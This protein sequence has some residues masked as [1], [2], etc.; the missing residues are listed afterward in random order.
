MN[1][2]SI[3]RYRKKIVLKIQDL[4]KDVKISSKNQKLK[5]IDKNAN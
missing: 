5:D 2:N 3:W 1:S 4:L